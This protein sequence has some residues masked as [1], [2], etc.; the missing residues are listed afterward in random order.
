MKVK[1]NMSANI[2]TTSVLFVKGIVIG[3]ANIIPG[4]SGGTIAVVLGIYAKLIEAISNIFGKPGKRKEYAIF[5]AT[6]FLGAGSAIVLLA[7]L[8]HYLLACH[9]QLTVLAFMGLIAGG[10][11]AIW[12]AHPDVKPNLPRLASFLIGTALVIIPAFWGPEIKGAAMANNSAVLEFGLANYIFLIFAGFMA[13]GGM[14]LPGISGSFVLV[15]MG[16]YAV[17]ISALKGF[18]VAPLL[19]V[20]AGAAAG[21]IVFSKIIE[22]ALKKAPAG[23][24]YFIL[25]LVAASLWVI[26]PGMPS[27]LKTVLAG[28]ALFMTGTAIS[29]LMSKLSPSNE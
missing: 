9:Y 26:F 1:E 6:V 20:G 11:P 23:T 28:G 15:L 4:V 21:I 8:M 13:G 27:S 5:L 3:V 18:V 2:K 14:I 25:G 12:R 29:Y 22:T 17:V 10:I 16:Q 19:S 7:N 24:Y